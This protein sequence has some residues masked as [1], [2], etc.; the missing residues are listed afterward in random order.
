MMWAVLLGCA[1]AHAAA[2]GLLSRVTPVEK[3]VTMMEELQ[4]KV[5]DEG[6]AEA[7]T[8][9]E[10]ACFCR[11]Q[12]KAKRDAITEAEA[13]IATLTST[14]AV[15]TTERQRLTNESNTLKD[16][17][18][19]LQEEIQNNTNDRTDQR[20]YY[21]SNN[22]QMTAN[23]AAIYAAAQNLK[24]KTGRPSLLQEDQTPDLSVPN[25]D[26]ES[27]SD[28]IVATLEGL[29]QTFRD[30]KA[31]LTRKEMA[32]QSQFERAIQAKKA[33][34]L[35]KETTAA[36]NDALVDSTSE[37]LA[38]L[39]AELTQT[40]STCND[41]KLYLAELSRVCEEKSVEWTQ[42]TT[43]RQRELV[44][45]GMAIK[46]LDDLPPAR[47]ALVATKAEVAP[48]FTQLR[49]VRKER[50]APEAPRSDWAPGSD[51]VQ[52]SKLF[53]DVGARLGAAQ[54]SA[55]A[56]TIV[57]D[58]FANVRTLIENLI[59]KLQQEQA[60]DA[61]KEGW[62]RE[63]TAKTEK[64]R[65]YRLGELDR[66]ETLNREQHAKQEALEE[67]RDTTIDAISKLRQA[68][69]TATSLRYQEQLENNQTL[70]DST[71]GENV[72]M[73]AFNVLEDY[74]SAAAG[75]TVNKS[76][77]DE[78]VS[79]YTGRGEAVDLGAPDTGAGG[80]YKGDQ[81]SSKGIL[82]MLEVIAKDFKRQ[83]REAA[84]QEA[85]QERDFTAYDR[86]TDLS[87]STK[88]SSLAECRINLGRNTDAAATSLS[89]A[90]T[91]QGLLDASA[92]SLVDLT[93]DCGGSS[94]LSSG[95]Q[96]VRS[97]G[98]SHDERTARRDAEIDALKDALCML[99]EQYGNEAWCS[100]KG[101]P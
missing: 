27:K 34:E 22:E 79:N 6:A 17:I 56:T 92:R 18:A 32:E 30:K 37:S 83:N 88:T 4:N 42:R 15:D 99:D 41:D 21:E 5:T 55:L 63:E 66:L 84:A 39:Q 95:G 36:D 29:H 94:A 61:T 38:Q 70:A 101:I 52:V 72:T 57:T 97:T 11:S 10:F 45:I 91:M 89:D 82:G 100:G 46:T 16:E 98:M 3:V 47:E 33:L 48:A 51:R 53:Q 69:S 93:A 58:Q 85:Q 71:L 35:Q 19:T 23:E 50:K 43:L 44:A 78:S 67:E 31:M 60:D 20:E 81:S 75:E 7:A 2:Q 25:A 40:S 80:A 49:L 77:A 28:G 59:T 76:E 64:E 62:C 13:K 8:Y 90:R 14:I 54:L 12:T 87:I 26:Y 86:E 65:D 74:Y 24:A 73:V 96:G 68:L 1:T 9:N